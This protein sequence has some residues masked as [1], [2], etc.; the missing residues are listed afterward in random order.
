MSTKYSE[1]NIPY[2]GDLHKAMAAQDR[3]A[4]RFLMTRRP[5]VQDTKTKEAD[6]DQECMIC[7]DSF[8]KGRRCKIECPGCQK[9]C[10]ASCFRQHLLLSSSTDP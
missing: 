9:G 7:M 10:C 8:N 6:M 2:E 3:E 4:I 5:V 1:Q